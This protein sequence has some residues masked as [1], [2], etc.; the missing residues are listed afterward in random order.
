VATPLACVVLERGLRQRVAD[1]WVA[2]SL[3]LA[4]L[5]AAG[6]SDGA[7]VVVS[8]PVLMLLIRVLVLTRDGSTRPF[9]VRPIKRTLLAVGLLGLGVAA[10]YAM[11]HPLSAG[12]S[13]GRG[14]ELA[15]ASTHR[16]VSFENRGR[17]AVSVRAVDP[18]LEGRALASPAWA[19]SRGARASCGGCRGR[20][21]PR[22]SPWRPAAGSPSS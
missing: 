11:A 8:V 22:R 4:A 12:G 6:G 7:E 19:R 16:S 3:A 15:Q 13:L 9:P 1:G 18:V 14:S 20:A 10:P 17:F 21:R 5:A 2:V